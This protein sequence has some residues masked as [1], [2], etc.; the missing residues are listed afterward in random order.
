MK[1]WLNRVHN[2]MPWAVGERPVFERALSG[3]YILVAVDLVY[4]ATCMVQA[5]FR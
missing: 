4:M 2:A 1:T 3:A 5:A